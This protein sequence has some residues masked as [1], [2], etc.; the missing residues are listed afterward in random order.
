MPRS[1][2]S[3]FKDGVSISGVS[4]NVHQKGKVFYVCSSSVVA[5]QG[6]GASDSNSGL[7]P[8]TPLSTIA[9]ALTNCTASRGDKI[10]LLPGHAETITAAA[11]ID[12]NV[13]GVE[14]IGVGK[15]AQRP[16]ITY[17]TANTATLRIKA[18]DVSIKNVLFVGNFLAIA[19]A[20]V[21]TTAKNAVIDECEFRD[22]S[23]V[24]GF[25]KAVQT[26]TTDNDADGLTVTNCKMFGTGTT[27]ATCLVNTAG[28]VDRLTVE[29]NVVLVQGTTGTTGVLLLSTS[30][31]VT[32][33]S[34]AHNV[35]QSLYTGSAG[36][37]IVGAAGSTG[38]VN[39]NKISITGGGT[40]LLC[41]AST[42]LGFHNNTIQSAADKSGTL[43]PVV[44]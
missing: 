5:A 28:V 33:A 17:T 22:N 12:L 39:D 25:V 29:D 21:L 44:E 35:A 1:R 19:A 42:G 16:T 26:S 7:T 38:I 41:T 27:A 8:E 14:I 2:F 32:S 15:G 20:I 24:L 30:K 31:A 23:S 36:C 13:A 10:V 4:L 43:S 18:V 9:Q 34:I 40:D 37:L 11:G 6:V 3:R